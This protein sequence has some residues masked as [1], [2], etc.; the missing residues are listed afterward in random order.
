[1]ISHNI[2]VARPELSRDV[3]ICNAALESGMFGGTGGGEGGGG[4]GGGGDGGG[5]GPGAAG[6]DDG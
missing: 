1:M 2:H 4:D 5:N 3:P 6:G